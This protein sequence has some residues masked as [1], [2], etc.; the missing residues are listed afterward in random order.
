MGGG[1][2]AGDAQAARTLD[3]VVP[4]AAGRRPGR[5]VPAAELLGDAARCFNRIV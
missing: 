3:L 1:A 4:A 2:A 5:R